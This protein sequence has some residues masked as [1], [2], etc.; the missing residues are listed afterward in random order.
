[1][2]DMHMFCHA[3]AF[4]GNQH[5]ILLSFS[6]KYCNKLPIVYTSLKP[7]KA[8]KTVPAKGGTK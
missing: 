8:K 4:Y 6:K 7:P 2:A 1:M 3:V 5:T